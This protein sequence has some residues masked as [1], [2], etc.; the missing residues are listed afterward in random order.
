MKYATLQKLC[1]EFAEVSLRLLATSD[2]KM[3]LTEA[4]TV[5]INENRTGYQTSSTLVP[6][7]H[8]YLFL[9]Y[10]EIANSSAFKSF[11]GYMFE[12]REIEQ[13]HSKREIERMLPQSFLAKLI[14]RERISWNFNEKKFN[15]IY[16][17]FE[18]YLF[19]ET[20]PYKFF[21]ILPQLKIESKEMVLNE[22]LKI[23]RMP[24]E[25]F[26]KLAGSFLTEFYHRFDFFPETLMLERVIQV[27]KKPRVVMNSP[28]REQSEETRN[29][30]IK[31]ITALRLFKKGKVGFDKIY[32]EVLSDWEGGRRSTDSS[33]TKSIGGNLQ[34]QKPE[35][36]DFIEFWNFLRDIDL[37][38]LDKNLRIAVNR[39][40]SAFMRRDLEDRLIDYVIALTS[41]FSKKNE[42]G[43]GRY[44]L[45]M[46][47][48]LFLAKEPET[49]KKIRKEILEIYDVRSAIVHGNEIKK[50]RHFKD[51]KT[52]VDGTEDYLR[53]S[54]KDL[55]QLSQK[56]GGRSKII[57]NIDNSLF[58]ALVDL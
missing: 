32:G 46:R 35:E 17:S 10:K 55:L 14:D 15:R 9:S 26:K 16:E 42:A 25:E 28:T 24:D 13:L 47:I 31:V 57:N 22:N 56:L 8:A 3:P 37:K 52:L 12:T 51:L 50:L 33:L 39:F 45:S 30:F 11:V 6:D 34:L 44:R 20:V 48:T 49:R 53:R 2:T 19:S 58:S 40:N 4:S 1:R 29:L 38:T 41:L 7:I 21:V 54:I 36:L 5:Q 27:R 43:L 18:N 23:K